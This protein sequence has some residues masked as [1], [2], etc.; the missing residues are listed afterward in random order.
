MPHRREFDGNLRSLA[1]NYMADFLTWL[2]GDD[3][4]LEQSLDTVLV[5]HE[6]RTDLLLRYSQPNDV[7]GILHLE[8]QKLVRKKSDLHFRMAEYCLRIR[9]KYGQMPKQVLILI[10]NTPLAR[11]VPSVFMEGTMRVEYQ[12]LRL[13][14][15]NPQDILNLGRPGLVPLVALMGSVEQLGERLAACGEIL[16]TEVQS[17]QERQDL[18][19]LTVFFAALQQRS[20]PVIESFLRSREMLNLLEESWLA[21]ELT[22]KAKAEGEARGEA[23][24]TQRHLIRLLTHKFGVLP[25]PVANTLL[26]IT[27]L[28]RLEE[29]IDIVIDAT[30]LQEFIS[31]L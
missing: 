16:T 23:K 13:W 31:Q 12:V 21:R 26:G 1:G 7:Q 22:A 30:S 14:E 5:A 9:S 27:D 19:A 10:E 20:A 25:E 29:L 28:S 24:A 4:I 18:L 11:A 2:V 17:T 8:F 15:L 6:R 3:A